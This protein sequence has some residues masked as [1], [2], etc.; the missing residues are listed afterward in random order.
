MINNSTYTTSK[1]NKLSNIQS[2]ID[3]WNSKYVNMKNFSSIEIY[4]YIELMKISKSSNV[5]ITI[6]PP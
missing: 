6:F 1:T 3:L 5:T 2:R 4:Y